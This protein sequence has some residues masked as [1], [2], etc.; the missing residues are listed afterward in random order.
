MTPPEND[1]RNRPRAAKKSRAPKLN[2]QLH[3]VGAL[4]SALPLLVVILSGLVLQLKKHWSWVQPPTRSGETA[5][6]ALDWDAVLASARTA[7][8]AGIETWDD[9]DRIDVRPSK[10]VMKVRAN[11]SWEV[12]IDASTGEVLQ[13]S[14]R[15]SD[16]I[17]SI[18]DGTFFGGDVVKLYVFLPAA[19]L[20][21]GLWV[22]GV[23]LWL[24]PHL[25]KRRRRQAAKP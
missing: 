21:F 14:Y 12:Q 19:V 5:E 16:L 3:R 24:L 17:E 23:Y 6:L 1:A 20:L 13:T 11:S 25:V 22:S 10:G 18:H 15:R 7:E 8:E 9:V 2:R 4:V